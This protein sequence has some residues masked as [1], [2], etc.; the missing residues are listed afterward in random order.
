MKVLKAIIPILIV[1]FLLVACGTKKVSYVGTWKMDA[2]SSDVILDLKGDK[3]FKL[4]DDK[5]SLSGTYEINDNVIVFEV[6]EIKESNPV[7]EH[8]KV[9]DTIECDIK[10]E[11]DILSISYDKDEFIFT[12]Q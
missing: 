12:K 8:I 7:N 2:G 11:N 10:L 9:G 4:S 6:K 3:T 1:L 5:G